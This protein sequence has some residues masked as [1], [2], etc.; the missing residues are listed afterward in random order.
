M[1]KQLIAALIAGSISS[2]ASA[3]SL[4]ISIRNLTHGNHFTPLLVAAHADSEHLF[5]TG[6]TASVN[7]QA[8]A[9]GGDISGLTTDMEAVQAN[10]SANPAEGLLAPGAATSLTLETSD[11]NTELSVVAMVLPT[12]DAFIGLNSIPIPSQAGS[13][14]YNINAY[15]AGTEANDE[16]ITGG[17]APGAA[18]IPADP[19]GSNGSNGT[20]VAGADANQTVHIS[21]GIIG[22]TDPEGGSSD[23]DSRVHRW[24]NP[25]AQ[26]ILVVK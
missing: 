18:G 19:L 11:T 8:M 21:R 10:I 3:Q 6:T 14:V 22:D 15:D 9:E 25:V 5:M 12:N 13:Y 26:L 23:L 24:L 1:K 16:L 17:G 7:L 2:I 20:G 4:E